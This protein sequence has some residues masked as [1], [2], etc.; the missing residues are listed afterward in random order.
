MEL[1]ISPPNVGKCEKTGEYTEEKK[2]ECRKCL[3]QEGMYYCEECQ[4]ARNVKQYCDPRR[5]VAKRIEQCERP[6]YQVSM[7][8]N[9]KC[10][11][12][13]DCKKGQLCERNQCIEGWEGVL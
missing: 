1:K 7:N 11:D 3:T 2:K 13:F 8:R 6:C 10:S 4:S 5:L 9:Q 12:D